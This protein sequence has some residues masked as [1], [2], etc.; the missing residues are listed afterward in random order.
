MTP[1]GKL[2]P[3][4]RS[5]LPPSAPPSLTGRRQR[6]TP[7][8]ARDLPPPVW[9]PHR[10]HAHG[11][12]PPPLPF[13]PPRSL[14]RP[15]FL[16]S[17]FPAAS[18]GGGGEGQAVLAE[19]LTSERVK[20]AAMLGLALA[21]CN[22]D[23][24]VMSVAIVPLSQAYGW[25]PSFAGVVQSS[26]LWGYLVSPIIGGALVDYYGGK[27]VMAYGV[28]LW[29][30]ATFLSPWAAA[31]SLWL[32]L[33]TRVLLGMAEGVAL[34]SMNNMV[35]RWFPRTERSSAVGIAMGG[36]Q[37]GNTIG[38]LLSPIIMSR[39]GI[40][41]PFVIFGLFGFLWV[42]VW[43][44]A[45]SGTPG[46]NTQISAHELD[47]ITRGQKL[48][49]TQTGSEKLRKVPPFR[50]LLSKSPTWALI[51]ANAMHSWGYFV[52]LSWMPVYFKT[53]YHVNL[54]EAAWFSALPWVMMAVL[55]YVAGVVSDM[56][57]RNGTS[58][59]LTRKIM[60]TIGF[61]GPGVALLGLNAAKNPITASAWLTI[62]VGLKSF[63]HSGFLV[64][65]QEIAPQYAG[66][67]HGMSNTAGTFAAI[68]GTVG[69]GFFVD[70]MGSF[71]G[72]L[73]L[74]S[75]LYFSSTL[76]WDIFATGE[77]VDFDGTG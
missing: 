31:R 12:L 72:F 1:P 63:G 19:F 55:G 29:S 26:F 24:V 30:L 27:R 37:L 10:L 71:R 57:I 76:F 43:I 13:A 20:V 73:I 15:P 41:G 46:E 22:A 64:N 25:T 36:F 8:H 51:S 21:L 61:V 14:A 75:L 2:L 58:I 53:I 66:V 59:T 70:R 23:R 33:A 67:L 62:A 47:Y 45:I 38:L 68:L 69:A 77:R 4:T 74:T 44:S 16:A 50:K 56:L 3:L 5:L 17:A 40:F 32:F 48:V 65:L 7:A 39:A 49:K 60:Q 28:A 9:L 52:I 42:L 35:L 6:P 54:R 18:S 11:R 34:P